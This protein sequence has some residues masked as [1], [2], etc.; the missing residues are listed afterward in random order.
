MY[1]RLTCIVSAGDAAVYVTP[2]DVHKYA[3]AIVALMDDEST[4]F[5]M[6]KLGRA[7][8]EQDLAWSHQRH[9]YLAVYQALVATGRPRD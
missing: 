5:Q 8:V 3:A 2:N 1:I 4:R 9:A 6:A 7:R